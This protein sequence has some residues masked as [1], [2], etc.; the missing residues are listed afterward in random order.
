MQ[1]VEV[2]GVSN[3]EGGVLFTDKEWRTAQ[4][5]SNYA[6]A[7]FVNIAAVPELR[8][9]KNPSALFSPRRTKNLSV[10]IGWQVSAAQLE[11]KDDHHE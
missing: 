7:L 8:V 10:H 6:L 5:N 3:R 1:L 2:K 4:N 11:Y 9:I